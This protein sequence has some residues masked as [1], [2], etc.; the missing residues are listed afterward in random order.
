MLPFFYI[1]GVADTTNIDQAPDAAM[2][3]IN[4]VGSGNSY[5]GGS[6][7]GNN[8]TYIPFKNDTLDEVAIYDKIL[9]AGDIGTLY[10]NGGILNLTSA[11]APQTSALV[12]WIRF[13]DAAGDPQTTSALTVSAGTGGTFYDQMGANNYTV[14]GSGG[15]ATRLWFT[16]NS[17]PSSSVSV[18]YVSGTKETHSY[19]TSPLYDNYNIQHQIPRADRQYM[20]IEQALQ[21]VGNIRYSGFQKVFDPGLMPF[22]T[23]SAGLTPFFDFVTQSQAK[24]NTYMQPTNRLTLVIDD[25]VSASTNTLGYPAGQNTNKYFNPTLIGVVNVPKRPD[26][27]NN[28]L[29]SRGA[30]YGWGWNKL[31][32]GD[33]KA[34]LIQQSRAELV[35]TKDNGQSLSTFRLPPVSFKGR[36]AVA[37]ID[38]PLPTKFN[39]DSLTNNSFTVTNTNEKIFFNEREMNN[40]AAINP[41][42]IYLPIGDLIR[43]G[44]KAGNRLNWVL[45]TQN[46]FPSLRNEGVSGT[47]KRVGYDNLYWRNA[48]AAR[49]TLGMGS[50]GAGT[51][52]S[53]SKAETIPILAL[54]NGAP[55]VV[56]QSSWLLDA[57]VNFMTRSS[58]PTGSDLFGSHKPV[59][60]EYNTR[61]TQAGELQNTYFAYLTLKGR[62]SAGI[63]MKPAALY[64]RKHALGSPR[65]VVSPQGPNIRQLIRGGVTLTGA[66]DGAQQIPILGGEAAW[67]ANT[68]AGII[69]KRQN[70]A[71]FVI[72]ASNPWY[73]DYDSFN[74]D[75]KLMA[76]GYSIVP[77]YRMSEHIDDYYKYS[78]N[79]KTKFDTFSIPGTSFSSSQPQFYKDYSNSDFLE[80]FLG[81]KAQ[82]LLK[83]R[84]IRMV[85]SASIKYNAYKG[86]YPAQRTLDLVTQ[87]AKSHR[88]SFSAQS[89]FF[90]SQGSGSF[91]GQDLWETLGGLMKPVLDPLVSP[92]ILYNSIKSGLAVDYPV[93]TDGTKI[94]RGRYGATAGLDTYAL[95]IRNLVADTQSEEGYSGGSYWD[96]RI[97]FEAIIEPKKYISN[98]GFVDNEASP[99]MSFG[100]PFKVPAAQGGTAKDK[101]TASMGDQGD[102]IYSLM[103]RNFFGEVGNFFLKNSEFTRLESN[104]VTDELRF[105]ENEVYMARIKLRRSHNGK[106]VYDYDVDSFGRSGSNKSYFARLGAKSSNAAG[107][108]S[109]TYYPIPQDPHQYSKF[110]ETFTL[111]SRP[112]AFGPPCA[113]RPTGSLANQANLSGAFRYALDSF[114]GYNP[115]FTPPYTNGEAWVDLI[116]RPSSGV[117]Y[118]LERILAEVKTVAWRFDA[119]YQ[120]PAGNS[121]SASMPALIPVLRAADVGYNS[122]TPGGDKTLPSIYDGYRINANSMQLSASINL[123]GVER[124]LEQTTDKFGRQGSTKNVSVGKKWVIQPKFETPMLNFAD[125]GIHPISN[126]NGTLTLPSKFS[127]SVPRG[128]WHQFGVIPNK[129][130]TGIFMEIDNIPTQWLKH[131]YN[132]VLENSPYN[133]NNTGSAANIHRRTKSLASLCGFNR[134]NS[135][136]R[137]GEI[138]EEMTIRE[139]GCRNSVYLRRDSYNQYRL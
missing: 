16:S 19:C 12:T 88:D 75:L 100:W 77:E 93:V 137:L 126:T 48:Q 59:N 104:T 40:I 72:S 24:I 41:R 31:R 128:M 47:V 120:I 68:Q 9:T 53:F 134:K 107:V 121:V 20:W 2:T 117:T 36:P 113:G 32:Q 116:F 54:P 14:K 109:K 86:F 124:V 111:Y 1:D 74:A 25:P 129:P 73:N 62:S 105:R 127:E 108:R 28:L 15:T 98:I 23:T 91:F 4:D 110:K 6:N 67:E 3:P 135:S 18:A 69:E 66:F 27:L 96:Q 132:V 10:S 103:A 7:K 38:T 139:G 57:P 118:D 71:S 56:G 136:Q 94:N 26:Y 61:Y 22:R 13:G 80:G 125:S 52:N 78:I 55:F 33:H 37:N 58:I 102:N 42:K 51:K 99:S 82:S 43:H 30:T 35:I 5:I 45:Y 131:H 87:F 95:G 92:G 130:S 64:A 90:T 122:T 133:N 60:P 115:A 83:A 84:E 17:S 138:K 50:N 119:G 70:S 112:T 123:F 39:R 89:S 49:I 46:I 65:S 81:I 114:E 85:C 11:L 101:V 106:R 63:Y 21:D 97:P 29:T 8:V 76:R 79:N 44:K 34:L